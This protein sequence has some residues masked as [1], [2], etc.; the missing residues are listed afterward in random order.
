MKLGNDYIA[1]V[2]ETVNT[3]R[4]WCGVLGSRHQEAPCP[5]HLARGEWLCPASC[6]VHLCTLA[7]GPPGASQCWSPPRELFE[8]SRAELG[9]PSVMQIVS[10]CLWLWCPPAV[11][12]NFTS[13][14]GMWGESMDGYG[15]LKFIIATREENPGV[16][17]WARYATLGQEGQNSESVLDIR[18]NQVARSLLNCVCARVHVCICVFL[19]VLH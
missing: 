10:S 14:Y 6:V 13:G 9:G 17:E 7:C 8:Q 3:T 5:V 19:F 2:S 12:A 16:T 11:P 15:P 4:A 1:A 18:L